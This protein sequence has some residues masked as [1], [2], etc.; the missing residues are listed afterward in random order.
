MTNNTT[1]DTTR[2]HKLLQLDSDDIAAQS[3]LETA[4]DRAGDD[5]RAVRLLGRACAQECID[6]V[7]LEHCDVY[8]E[9]SVLD[10]D[11][12]ALYEQL[13]RKHTDEEGQAFQEAYCEAWT[14]LLIAACQAHA[15]TPESVDRIRVA[16]AEA[17][18]VDGRRESDG[19]N[20]GL[21][22]Q[23]V[24]AYQH[25]YQPIGALDWTEL[26]VEALW[27]EMGVHGGDF[28]LSLESCEAIGADPAGT[29]RDLIEGTIETVTVTP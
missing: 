13:G 22:T 2:A 9:D 10:G 28:Q 25:S 19:A 27:A 5:Y 6:A 7:A 20:N 18:A 11:W 29:L 1:N 4:R 3:A 26:V 15:V 14:E 17:Q 24:D 23:G 12:E 16:A 8:T 21:G